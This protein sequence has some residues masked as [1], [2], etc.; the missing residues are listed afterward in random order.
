MKEELVTYVRELPPTAQE[1]AAHN[2]S[3]EKSE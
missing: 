2:P 3:M 1:V